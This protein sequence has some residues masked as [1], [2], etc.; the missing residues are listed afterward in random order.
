MW[1]PTCVLILFLREMRITLELV[2]D[3]L[4][5]GEAAGYIVGVLLPI[6]DCTSGFVFQNL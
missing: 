3:D 1:L 6:L 4:S 5:C 2:Q